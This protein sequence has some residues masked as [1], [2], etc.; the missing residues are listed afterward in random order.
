LL[1]DVTATPGSVSTTATVGVP[2]S[3]RDPLRTNTSHPDP[4]TTLVRSDLA[5]T[6]TDG[7]TS[8]NAGGQ[9]T[10]T[11]K[12]TNNGPS[13]VAGTLSDPSAAGLPKTTT[14]ACSAAVNN[15]CVSAPTKAQL[16]AGFTLPSLASGE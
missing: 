9:T 15:K 6:K 3:V 13:A 11:I 10:Y 2:A 16:E 8:V 5:V 12:V 4:Y 7:V 14:I 1:T